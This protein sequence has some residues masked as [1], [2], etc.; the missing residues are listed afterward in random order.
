[1]RT[2]YCVLPWL[3]NVRVRKD[4]KL[5]DE[6]CMYKP[7]LTGSSLARFHSSP[8]LLLKQRLAKSWKGE[9]VPPLLLSA[10]HHHKL[11]QHGSLSTMHGCGMD[12]QPAHWT[13]VSLVFSFCLD[14][15]GRISARTVLCR[16]HAVY[17]S[18]VGQ[19]PW[20]DPR[21]ARNLK[22]CAISY[23]VLYAVNRV[24][25]L[26]GVPRRRCHHVTQPVGW[27]YY[28]ISYM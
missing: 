13:R 21:V 19:R 11:R 5:T 26:V 7:S 18:V 23:C 9:R 10:P 12:G 28:K 3:G 15:C 1:M 25:G 16:E 17:V 22:V 20:H 24:R 14:H 27:D 4:T 6:I 2:R 8:R